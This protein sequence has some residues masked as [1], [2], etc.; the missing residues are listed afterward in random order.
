MSRR[1]AFE[2][3]LALLYKA[4]LGDARWS[5]AAGVIDEVAHIKGSA[6]AFVE[7]TS[8]PEV[9]FFFLR[10]CLGGKHRKD[11]ER[12]YFKD[13]WLWD[14]ALLRVGPLPSGQ[15]VRTD[16]L[17]TDHEKKVSAAYNEARSQAQMQRGLTVRLDGPQ[18]SHIVWNLADSAASGG[19]WDSEQLETIT[20]LLPHVRQFVRMRQVLADAGAL[21]SSLV[22]LLDNTNFGVIQLD[23]QGRIVVT[24]D[25][26]RELLKQSD[27]LLDSGGFLR[28]RMP[29]ENQVLQRLLGRALRPLGVRAS[30]GSMT[31]HR[32][33]A[34]TQLG[35]QINPVP[36]LE[37]QAAVQGAAVLVLV[38]D[39]ATPAPRIDPEVVGMAL[40]LTPTESALAVMLA[41]GHSVSQIAAQTGRTEGTVRWHLKQIFQKLHI[42]RQTDLVLRILALNG[43]PRPPQ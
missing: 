20:R 5:D 37:S 16:D 18:N 4:A 28:A 38:V 12:E 17:Y 33:I 31:I 1:D 40:G 10:L 32:A 26:A 2:R 22:D 19:C 23:R 36:R 9:D 41:V 21:G 11:L 7:G 35:V 42:T 15:L 34:R 25:R 27:G 39:P 43:F 24:N 30:G 13:Y 29:A 3:A 14:E 6:L 8:Q